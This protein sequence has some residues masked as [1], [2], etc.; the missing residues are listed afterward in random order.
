[1]LENF[2]NNSSKNI[3][4]LYIE[5]KIA[6][7]KYRID[8]SIIFI[9]YVEAPLEFRGTGAAGKLMQHIM[10]FANKEKMEIKPI[11]S[12]AKQWLDKNK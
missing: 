8:N 12:Y 4:E 7:A 9:D 5:D 1:M 11:C 10:D 3:F 6:F 2:I